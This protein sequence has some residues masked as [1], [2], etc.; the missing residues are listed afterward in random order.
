MWRLQ[1]LCLLLLAFINGAGATETRLRREEER[2]LEAVEVPSEDDIARIRGGNVSTTAFTWLGVFDTGNCGVVLVHSDIVLT[3]AHCVKQFGYPNAVRIQ[4]LQ[5]DQGGTVVPIKRG[6]IHPDYNG[7]PADGADIAVLQLGSM[8]TNTVA[9]LNEDPQ[10]PNP[11]DQT[12]FMAGWGLMQDDNNMSPLV[13]QGLFLENVENCF[14]R[15][16]PVYNPEFHFCGDATPEKG[17]CAGDAGI[18]ILLPGTR[19]VVGLNSFSDRPC[20]MQTVDVYTRMSTYSE[21]AKKTICEMSDEPPAECAKEEICL[22]D[23]IFKFVSGVFG[24]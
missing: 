24:F 22:F 23:E 8:L 19:V 7:K 2:S 16:P 4:S 21:W 9:L 13:L 17:T 6:L 14:E 5:I 12:L 1:Q 3:T 18:P 10:V 11:E 20:E 15:A